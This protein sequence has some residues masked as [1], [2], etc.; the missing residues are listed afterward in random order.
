MHHWQAIDEQNDVIPVVAGIG[1]DTQLINHFKAVFAPVLD[2]DQRVVKRRAIVTLKTVALAQ[3]PGS[4]EYVGRDDGFQQAG[5][6]AIG[7]LNGV[8]FLEVFTK[9][10][11]QRRAIV[12]VGTIC[13]FKVF[14]FG[15]QFLLNLIFFCHE[16]ILKR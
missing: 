3:A 16:S 15:D 4:L 8:E 7:Q 10:F 2:I 13:I 11:F 6:F 1:I 14:Q 5:E 9:I 12:Y